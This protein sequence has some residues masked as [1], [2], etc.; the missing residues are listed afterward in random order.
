MLFSLMVRMFP[1]VMII[2]PLFILMRSVGLLDSRFGPT[3]GVAK[4]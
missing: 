3:A 2:V 4:G 1:S